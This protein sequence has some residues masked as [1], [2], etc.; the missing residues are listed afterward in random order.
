MKPLVIIPAMADGSTR[1]FAAAFRAVGFD[2]EVTPPSDARTLELGARYTSGDECLPAKIT[3]GDFLKVLQDDKTDVSRILLFM[4][5]ADG[6]CRFGMYAPY[7]RNVLNTN[8]YPGVRILSPNCDDGYA[9]LGRIAKVFFRTAWR[10]AVAGDILTKLLLMTRP[11]E[12][13]IGETDLA[14]QESL[15]A[16]SIIIA[17]PPVSPRS[18]LR[19]I[20][21]QLTRCRTRFRGIPVRFIPKPLIGIVG[22][23][24]CRL[25]SFA[26]QDVIRRLEEYGAET[27]LSGFTEWVWYANSEELRLLKLWGR[28]LGWRAWLARIRSSVQRRDEEA[29]LEPFRR[30]FADRPE[31]RIEEVLN[32]ARPYL[33]PEGATGEMVLNV[34]NVPCMARRGV[35][36]IID[37]S[38]FTC[39]NGIVSE[40]IYP[41]LSKDLGG[42][43]I[44]NLYF[45]G[46]Q[47]DLDS[48][49]GVFMDMARAYRVRRTGGIE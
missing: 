43:P 44:R 7:L 15:D 10:A 20:R 3:I 9:S 40:A 35:S 21:S 8:G 45:D 17:T 29:L 27:W 36:G 24:F 25:N 13:R 28:N 4:A 49:L 14:Y 22:E 12:S 1:L 19:A 6:P 31:A 30:D 26:N 5:L 39:M 37:I 2:A 32:A 18:Q 46:T 42:L 47:T 33:P 34:G 48:E 16:L 11:Y 38:P 23:I 41:R